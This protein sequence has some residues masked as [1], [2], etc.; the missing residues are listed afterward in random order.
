MQ[1][2]PNPNIAPAHALWVELATR[3]ATQNLH[4]RAGGEEA[5]A[6]SVFSLFPIARKLLTEHPDAADFR[7]SRWSCSTARCARTRRVGI[8]G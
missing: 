6:R 2:A 7:A 5:A 4:F 1:N 8:V 3:T